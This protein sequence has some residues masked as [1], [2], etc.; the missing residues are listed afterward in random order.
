MKDYRLNEKELTVLRIAHKGVKDKRKAD[1]IKAIYLLGIGWQISA[2]REAL[3][4]DE[5][6]LRNYYAR[7]E[8]G[9]LMGLL[10]DK[11]VNNKD[12]LCNKES[13]YLDIH[14]QEVTYRT[15]KEII[16]FVKNEFEVEYSLSGMRKLLKGLGYVYKKPQPRP[17]KANKQE[18]ANFR[19]WYTEMK[20]KLGSV[21]GCYFMDATHPKHETLVEYGW[22]KRGERRE[23]ATTAK[24]PS[25]TILGALD[26]NKKHVVSSLFR[27][28]MT[29]ERALDM[30][31]KLRSY[32]PEGWIYLICDKA[33]YFH[34]DDVKE[35]AKQLGIKLKYLPA[36][37]PNLN[38]IERVWLYFKKVTLYNRYFLTYAEFEHACR[39]FFRWQRKHAAALE[40]LLVEKFQHLAFT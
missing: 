19:R 9:H 14:L 5:D 3:L 17:A 37:S 20:K 12:L 21:D 36:Y 29:T 13:H 25:L 6:T 27:G 18:Q 34:N 30:L 15:T 33:G 31:D 16:E 32:Q 26:I 39:D 23:I 28:M 8:D 40:T 22:I 35:Y 2:V 4:L 1:K 24:Q 11:Y 7:Y 38:L 10:D